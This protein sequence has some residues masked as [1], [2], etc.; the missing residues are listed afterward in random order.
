MIVA[1]HVVDVL[2]IQPR[3]IHGP[4]GFRYLVFE[5]LFAIHASCFTPRFSEYIYA[6]EIF[7]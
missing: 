5:P 2:D 4:S 1:R 6:R 3:I 7:F